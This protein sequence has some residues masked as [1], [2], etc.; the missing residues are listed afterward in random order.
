MANALWVTGSANPFFVLQRRRG[1]QGRRPH[2]WKARGGRA[3]GRRRGAGE[4]GAPASEGRPPARPGRRAALRTRTSA[5]GGAGGAGPGRGAGAGGREAG[6]ERAVGAG[7]GGAGKDRAGASRR[8]ICARVKGGRG[9][10]GRAGGQ[11]K[12]GGG[13]PDS[14]PGT[15]GAPREGLCSCPARVSRRREFAGSPGPLLPPGPPRRG[16]EDTSIPFLL[17]LLSPLTEELPFF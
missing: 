4:E 14:A 1:R 15:F 12:A 7:R 3:C 6:R 17:L 2:G 9:A 13:L 5:R 10:C 11:K 16:R 8:N